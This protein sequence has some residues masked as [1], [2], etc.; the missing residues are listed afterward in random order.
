MSHSWAVSKCGILFL[1]RDCP[2]NLRICGMVMRRVCVR[3][4]EMGDF[5]R[6]SWGGN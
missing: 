2:F 4:G 3:R 1:F 6:K 5:W